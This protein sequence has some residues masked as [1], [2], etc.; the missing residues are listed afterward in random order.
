MNM[1]ANPCVR[2][3]DQASE[4]EEEFE[5]RKFAKVKG[6]IQETNMVFEKAVLASHPESR[7]TAWER[8]DQTAQEAA[9]DGAE[10]GKLKIQTL[11]PQP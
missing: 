8:V 9:T 11:S 2:P 10:S 4:T 1:E 3:R 7:T 5:A 6:D